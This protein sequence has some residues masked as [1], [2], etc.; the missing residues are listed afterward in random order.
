M[1]PQAEQEVEFWSTFL[2]RGEDLERGSDVNL[3][4][5]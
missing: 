2:V 5:L 1:H 4:V 3:E